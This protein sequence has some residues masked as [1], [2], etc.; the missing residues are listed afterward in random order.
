MRTITLSVPVSVNDDAR[1]Q[2]EVVK[3]LCDTITAAVDGPG[4]T[5]QAITVSGTS[6]GTVEVEA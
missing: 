1:P 3:T 5:V 6:D 4:Q 2:D